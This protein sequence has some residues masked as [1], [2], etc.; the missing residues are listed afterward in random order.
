MVFVGHAPFNPSFAFWSN[1]L[2]LGYDSVVAFFVLSGYVISYSATEKEKTPLNYTLAR[3]ARIYP[4]AIGTILVALCLQI[5]AEPLSPNLYTHY[6]GQLEN[7]PSVIAQCLL[8]LNEAWWFDVKPFA[9]GPYWSL[10]FEVWDYVAYGV[11]IFL[12]GWKRAAL[13]IA[14][15]AL[16]GPKFL[17]LLPVWAIGSTTYHFGRKW[18]FNKPTAWVMTIVPIVI[19]AAFK[20][21]LPSTWSYHLL[22]QK[23]EELF[24]HGLDGAAAFLWA[25]IMGA[26]FAV[27]LV[28]VYNLTASR[29]RKW[30]TL[31]HII[32]FF[33]DLSFTLYMI[34]MPVTYFIYAY[35][36][37]SFQQPGPEGK[38]LIYGTVL[39][40]SYTFSA[41]IEKSRHQLRNG[42]RVFLSKMRIVQAQPSID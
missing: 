5:V 13:L 18:T 20:L 2:N 1:K 35:L 19:Y 32:T 10:P 24:H 21:L 36:A 7:A 31:S 38:V 23:I 29:V 34:H 15:L 22:G 9:M 42:I 8:F 25:T 30:V 41:L 40:V 26:L 16:L 11:L 33:S 14:I 12:N 28:G 39:A 37:P 4:V 17:L 3:I 27:H 6:H